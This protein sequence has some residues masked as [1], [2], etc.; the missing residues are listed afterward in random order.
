MARGDCRLAKGCFKV[1][2][3]SVKEMFSGSPRPP[4]PRLRAA[5]KFR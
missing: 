2:K 4:N 3:G 1:R 5:R